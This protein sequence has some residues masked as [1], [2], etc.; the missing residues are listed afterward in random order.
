MQSHDTAQALG[1]QERTL[2]SRARRLTARGAQAL[3]T[4]GTGAWRCGTAAWGCDT[5]GGPDHDKMPVHAW[6]CWPGC[7]CAHC[8]PDQF[9][10]STLFLSYRLDT[11][12]HKKISEIFFLIK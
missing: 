9:L 5:A 3:G 6:A 4:G 1:A 7:V 12:H 10:D 2:G 8:A 11:V